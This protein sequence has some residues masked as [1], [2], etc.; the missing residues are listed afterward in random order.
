MH[1]ERKNGLAAKLALALI[2][3]SL[4]GCAGAD[5]GAIPSDLF[6]AG[7]GQLGTW[8]SLPHAVNNGEGDLTFD[9]PVCSKENLMNGWTEKSAKIENGVLYA[10]AVFAPQFLRGP[11]NG[12]D[13]K[14]FVYFE[15]VRAGAF[16]HT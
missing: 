1:D 6:Q 10:H 2:A 16:Y 15:E 8:R 5:K 12:V 4:V 13:G 3:L 14:D 11:C 9:L 7:Q